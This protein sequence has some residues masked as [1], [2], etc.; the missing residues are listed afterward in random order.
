MS[1]LNPRIVYEKKALELR[2]YPPVLKELAQ[3]T[4]PGLS[5]ESKSEI[6]HLQLQWSMWIHSFL[7]CYSSLDLFNN[8][9]NY[10]ED[11]WTKLC[12]VVNSA[13]FHDLSRKN[14]S[15]DHKELFCLIKLKCIFEVSRWRDPHPYTGEIDQ[16]F[17]ITIK[18][19]GL[20]VSGKSI[21][22][23]TMLEL[24]RAFTTLVEKFESLY[25]SE[26]VEHY[27]RCLV[28]RASF[29]AYTDGFT[30][31]KDIYDFDFWFEAVPEEKDTRYTITQRFLRDIE[32]LMSN[33]ELRFRSRTDIL[34]RTKTTS[35]TSYL[36]AQHKEHLTTFWDFLK[37]EVNNHAI[38]KLVIDKLWSTVWPPCLLMGEL[39]RYKWTHEEPNPSLVSVISA[40]RPLF[41]RTMTDRITNNPLKV[42]STTDIFSPVHC[43]STPD[44][45]AIHMGVASFFYQSVMP[46]TP[47][48]EDYIYYPHEIAIPFQNNVFVK[49]RY[50]VILK[51]FTEWAVYNPLDGTVITC[52]NF[53]D[54]FLLW[55]DVYSCQ[56][57]KAHELYIRNISFLKGRIFGSVS[58][59]KQSFDSFYSNH[60]EFVGNRN[61]SPHSLLPKPE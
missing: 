19:L 30:V 43:M 58:K 47:K 54:C 50:P 17:F 13:L 5:T 9:E 40:K 26:D 39:E 22:D 35:S 11:L 23:Y 24:N 6:A 29:F 10:N 1:N 44:M 15:F 16:P 57:N 49:S 31:I 55:I 46:P 3:V 36:G 14:M 34:L 38:N 27:F 28:H 42:F 20:Q 41:V 8:N 61:P 2:T 60:F 56:K 59:S 12:D 48:F 37:K 33:I 4:F 52:L 25:Y 32:L 21:V 51:F 7:S 45:N 53:L 18:T